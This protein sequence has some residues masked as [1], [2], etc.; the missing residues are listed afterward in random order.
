MSSSATAQDYTKVSEEYFIAVKNGNMDA[1]EREVIVVDAKSVDHTVE[2]AEKSNAV[3]IH[4]P[5]RSR[6]CQMNLGASA[7]KSEI[8]YFVH[9]D[10]KALKFFC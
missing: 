5:I 1:A 9:A 10:V 2:I 6:A 8:L 3:V 4:S 7:A